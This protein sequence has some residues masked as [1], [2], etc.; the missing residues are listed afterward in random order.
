MWIV[1]SQNEEGLT[2]KAELP[3]GIFTFTLWYE[4]GAYFAACNE[5]KTGPVVL[6]STVYDLACFEA[7]RELFAHYKA[8]NAEFVEKYIGYQKY[9]TDSLNKKGVQ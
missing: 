2:T 1:K 6:K 8:A 9:F 4:D 5:L 7:A 3:L